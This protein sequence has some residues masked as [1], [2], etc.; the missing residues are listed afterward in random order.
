[1]VCFASSRPEGDL[2]HPP[3]PLLLFPS[4]S[5]FF[6][7]FPPSSLSFSSLFS[8]SFFYRTISPFWK[9]CNDYSMLSERSANAQWPVRPLLIYLSTVRLFFD[10]SSQH[11]LTLQTLSP[12][13]S[14][15]PFP[16]F[17]SVFL[18]QWNDCVFPTKKWVK[19]DS[20][21]NNNRKKVKKYEEAEEDED[22]TNLASNEHT[23]NTNESF[24][25]QESEGVRERER[26]REREK[27]DH[28]KHSQ[29][30][31]KICF[32]PILGRSFCVLCVCD[33]S[34]TH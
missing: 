12:S 29:I 20:D 15:P 7:K 21:P 11:S 30:D 23:K 32:N 19:F 25:S 34:S 14:L 33:S 4:H 26:E 6:S 17:V 31:E 28:K 13:L 16:F 10:V 8:P 22:R 5:F 1:M 2:C 18:C 27:S 3:P 24:H 9:D